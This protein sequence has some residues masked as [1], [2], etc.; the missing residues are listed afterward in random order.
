MN[1]PM[2]AAIPMIKDRMQASSGSA[3]ILFIVFIFLVF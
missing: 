2:L 3:K 1:N